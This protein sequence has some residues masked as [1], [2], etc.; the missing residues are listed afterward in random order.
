VTIEDDA[1]PTLTE[2]VTLQGESTLS[3]ELL[4]DLQADL[5]ARVV[6]LTEEL[7]H[8]A[9]R[10]V[11]GVLFERVCDRLRA[12]LPDLVD[13]VLKDRLTK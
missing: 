8:S 2:V 13:Q 10:E 9:S 1:I 12:H 6:R 5:T 11:E 4:A 7:M 3:P